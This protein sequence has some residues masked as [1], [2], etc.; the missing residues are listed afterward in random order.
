M[1]GVFR[2]FA[3]RGNLIDLAVAVILGLAFNAVVV[4]LVDGVFMQLIAAAVGQPDFSRLTFDVAG[5]PIRYGDFLTALVDFLLIAFVLF[6][7]VRGINR[8]MSLRGE[9]DEPPRV[10]ACPFCLT[11]IPV[12][13]QRC[14][15][16]TSHVEPE[17]V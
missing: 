1:L 6:L 11:D 17:R 12:G 9:K 16:C 4:A 14:S 10:R 8:A 3:F 7:I 13:A 5:T 2:K 15:A